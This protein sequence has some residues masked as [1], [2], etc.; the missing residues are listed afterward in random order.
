VYI[1]CALEDHK[2]AAAIFDAC[3]RLAHS[4]PEIAITAV[5]GWRRSRAFGRLPNVTLI[6]FQRRADLP[7]LIGAHDVVIGQV[8]LGALGMAEMEAM[9]C[10][11]PLVGW[12]NY[13]VAYAEQP[14][15]A[16]ANQGRAIA[17][18]VARLVDDG[19]AREVLGTAG[20]EWVVRYHSL[21]QVS[22]RVEAVLAR[23]I[24]AARC[25]DRES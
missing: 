5:G 17:D 2:G 8:Q 3:Q 7:A 14:P 18:A 22:G 4:R 6:P 10:G 1:A 23:L 20:R 15:I 11:R 12:F 24:E 13:P 9:S 19:A 25:A 21:E 16:S